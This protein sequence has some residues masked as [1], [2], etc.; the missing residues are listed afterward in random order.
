MMRRVVIFLIIAGLIA[1]GVYAY[2][3]WQQGQQVSALEGLQTTPA[4]R[5]GLTATIG[6]TGLVRSAQTVQLAWKTTGTV[7]NV[8]VKVGDTVKAGDRLAELEQTSLPQNVI[9]ARA[10]LVS[11]QQALDD[12]YSNASDAVVQAL[13]AISDQTKAVRNAQYQLD[14]FSVP[15]EMQK[16]TAVDAFQAMQKRLDG[17]RAAFEPV[18]YFP[19]GDAR[20]Q[21]LKEALDQ[22]QSDYDT[23]IRRLD[24]EYGLQ[25]A[26]SNLQ[27]ARDEY[28]KWKNGPG[29]DEVAAA[30][31]RIA[32]AQAT[33]NQSW[34]EAP[35]EGTITLVETLPGDQVA[36]AAPAFRLDNLD[37]ILV[38]LSVSEVD[39][40]QVALEQ[41]VTMSF[42]AV[43]GKEYHGVVSEVDRVGTLNQ[44]AVEFIVTVE[45]SDADADVRPG[46]TA[47]VNVVVNQLEDVLLVPNRAVRFQEGKTVVYVL[48]DGQLVTVNI[49]LGA[50]SD[51]ASEVVAGDLQQGDAI[52]LNPPTVFDQNGPPP[53]I[54]R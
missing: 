37:A 50:T 36:L 21:D 28:E 20:R 47:A 4:E 25:V 42:D 51:V 15:S 8:L 6:A 27:K 1:A 46:M 16:M 53:F 31:A 39:I 54:R 33:L 2:M 43:R 30:Q 48:K 22:A 29:E 32:A 24:Y 7:K 44:G 38:D 34:I 26:Q 23:A 18:K 13:Q 9:L 49:T 14:N 19:S 12:L 41:P 11:A 35:V 10:E 5:G 52:V 45:L 40:N 3:Q 17:A